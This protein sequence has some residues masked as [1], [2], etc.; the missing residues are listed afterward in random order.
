MFVLFF[1]R[2]H[3]ASNIYQDNRDLDTE[4]DPRKAELWYWICWIWH[5][6]I[7][8]NSLMGKLNSMLIF[9]FFYIL[10]Y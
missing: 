6:K 5:Q 7:S 3:S 4:L 1:L 10:I 9:F 2:W 8:R